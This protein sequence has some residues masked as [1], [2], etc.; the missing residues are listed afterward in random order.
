MS[1]SEIPQH[2]R[3]L[4]I[5]WLLSR[6]RP[7]DQAPTI[8]LE[9]LDQFR[10][11]LLDENRSR[12][13]R[14]QVAN[15]PRLLQMLEELIAADELVAQLDTQGANAPKALTAVQS[16][17]EKASEA[18][19]NFLSPSWSGGLA[20][21]ATLVI[22]VVMLAPMMQSPSLDSQLDDYYADL[23][24]TAS[25]VHWPWR[26]RIILRGGSVE[27]GTPSTTKQ[28]FMYGVSQG[29][30]K[31]QASGRLIPG[32]AG[33]LPEE[34]PLCLSVDVSC[35]REISLATSTGKW[36]LASFLACQSP[37]S[38]IDAT[39]Q[40]VFTTLSDQWAALSPSTD[41]GALIN[42]YSLKGPGCKDVEELL[43]WGG[44]N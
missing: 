36:A 43:R 13:V 14:K 38:S 35:E 27:T 21:A 37:A 26:P 34:A 1:D 5:A 31:L 6:E 33:R 18:L 39:G 19:T 25:D 40:A 2:S 8:D 4:G 24:S 42:T 9:T 32:S 10:T 29:L 44:K 11:G 22:L 16:W 28:A 3:E 12:E 20:A 41:L 17:W 15:D 30:K 23:K 7:S